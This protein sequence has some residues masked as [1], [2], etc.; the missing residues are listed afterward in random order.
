MLLIQIGAA[1]IVVSYYQF[2]GM[3]A[4]CSRLAEIKTNGG[5]LFSGTVGAFAGGIVPEI[6]KLA[7]GQKFER[8]RWKDILLVCA[9]FAW[10]GVTVDIMYAWFGRL[11]GA[12]HAVLTI[13][14][15]NATDMGVFC[16]FVAVPTSVLAFTWMD[17]RFNGAATK[18]AWRNGGFWDRYIKILL[19]NWMVWIPVLFAVYAL[20]VNL[21]F[22]MAELAEAAWSI[23]VVSIS[24]AEVSTAEGP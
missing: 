6:A 8:G 16:P 2:S 1:A 14:K 3:E 19:P 17:M 11:Y 7:T 5:L 10:M 24:R 21:Q 20:P 12:D 15:K 18:A 22:L 13:L 9:Y 23:L 4:F